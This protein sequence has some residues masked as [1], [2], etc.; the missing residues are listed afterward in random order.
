LN[1]VA[2]FSIAK[3]DSKQLAYPAVSISRHAFKF[4]T[5]KSKYPH[6]FVIFIDGNAF[7]AV[8]IAQTPIFSCTR[9]VRPIYRAYL[10]SSDTV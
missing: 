8:A 9:A 7:Q 10:G 3:K 5:G 2:V 1:A 4:F 6:Y